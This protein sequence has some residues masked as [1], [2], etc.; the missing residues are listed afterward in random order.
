[1]DIEN[2]LRQILKAEAERMKGTPEM[3]NRILSSISYK[4]EQKRM[5]K[6]L[7]AGVAAAAIM[8]PTA[9]FAGYSYLSDGIFGSQENFVA[10]GGT[11]A[12]YQHVEEK[13]AQAKRV[14]NSKEYKEMEALLKE[15]AGYHAKM[16]G[17]DGTLDASRLSEEEKQ[18]YNQLEKELA[19]YSAKIMAAEESPVDTLT[20]EESQKLLT[21]PVRKPTYVP[22]GYVLRT[23]VGAVS[24]DTKERKPVINIYYEKG[25]EGLGILQQ[26]LEDPDDI[27]LFG[28]Y[29][30]IKEYTLEGFQA[31]YGEKD[32]RNANGLSLI[33]PAKG[34]QSAYHIHVSGP[35][36]K[37][38]LEKVALSIVQQ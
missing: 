30:N 23:E 2:R 21:F 20:L 1:M 31:L 11:K 32:K 27:H 12:E 24:K 13:L 28:T 8:I 16:A 26:E 9:G 37:A 38:E 4:G 14:L 22:E 6:R 7:I 33:V 5:K 36:P 10:Q 19:P 34:K 35:L 18:R 29:S 17:P 3:R 15:A 25:E